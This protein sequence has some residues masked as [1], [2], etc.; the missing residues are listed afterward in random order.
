MNIQTSDISACLAACLIMVLMVCSNINN[1]TPTE[2]VSVNESCRQSITFI[3]GVDKTDQQ[4]YALAADH[5]ALDP[6]EKTDLVIRTCRTISDVIDFLNYLSQNRSAPWS[7]INIVAHGNPQTG[8]NLYITENGHKATPKRLLQA[9]LRGD[10]PVLNP[11]IVDSMTH[12]N[13]W[14]C[15]IGTSAMIQIA[16]RKIFKPEDGDSAKIHCPTEYVVFH[17]SLT[18]TAPRRVSASYWPYFFRRGYRPS[19]SEIAQALRSQYPQEKVAW[20]RALQYDERADS[21]EAYH[22]EYHIPASLV[23]IYPSKESRPDLDTKEQQ[24]QWVLQQEELVKQVEDSGI[25][26][27]KFHWTVNKIIYT[28][29]NGEVVPAI[30]A[31]GMATVL[32]VLREGRTQPS[33]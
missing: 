13:F 17:P 6:W 7:R 14:S 20:D 11:G 8:L 12:I 29:N 28:K 33:T 1:N 24:M 23:R 22:D 9:A 4:Y 27:D 21:I 18:G 26:I 30:K 2:E 32:I 10:T 19:D 25:P 3:M 16:L 5:F 31:I 15:G